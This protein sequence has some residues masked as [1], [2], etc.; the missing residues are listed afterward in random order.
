M[1]PG[2]VTPGLVAEAAVGTWGLIERPVPR[3][4]TSDMLLD[5]LNACAARS[6]IVCGACEP[7][8]AENCTAWIAGLTPDGGLCVVVFSACEM[9]GCAR[10]LTG[11]SGR[12]CGFSSYS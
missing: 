11:I 5:C 10:L 2:D 8:R 4:T 1:P 6:A 3:L 7:E 9:L 12:P